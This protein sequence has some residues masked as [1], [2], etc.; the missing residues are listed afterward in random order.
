MFNQN[1]KTDKI[2]SHRYFKIDAQS[3]WELSENTE[4]FICDRYQYVQIH[5]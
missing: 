4:C 5:F 1:P 2:D 3:S